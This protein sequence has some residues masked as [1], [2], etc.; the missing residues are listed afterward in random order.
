MSFLTVHFDD[1]GTHLESPIA[2]AACY[3]AKVERWKKFE[4]KW[5]RAKAKFNFATFHMADFAA[6]RGEFRKWGKSKQ[7]KVLKHLCWIVNSSVE[8]GFAVA[9]PKPIYDA[10]I[11]GPFRKSFVGDFH[12]TF[13]VLL[14]RIRKRGFL[15]MRRFAE[16][17]TAGWKGAAKRRGLWLPDIASS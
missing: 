3:A 1:S 2:I 11:T 15:I 12:Y 13:A 8:F 9:V 6:N 7:R 4:R 5:N 16:G 17:L 14:A 10:V